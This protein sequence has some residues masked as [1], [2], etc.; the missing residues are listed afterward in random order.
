VLGALRR[1]LPEFLKTG[2]PLSP[3][4]RRAIWAITHCR[5][6]ALGGRA[7]A[8]DPCG[9][10]HFAYHSCNHKACPQ[11]GAQ[12]TQRWVDRELGKLVNAPYF[13]VTFTLP[14]ELRGC[15]FGPLAKEAYDLFFAAVSGALTEKL[16]T[17][18]GLRAHVNGFTAVLHTWTQQLEFHPHI[19]CLVPGA[20]LDDQGN[21]VHVK[22]PEYLVYLDHLQN[23]F[24]QHFYRLLKEHDWPVDPAVWRKDWGVHIQAAGSGSAAVKY[25]GRYIARTAI[26]DQRLVALDEHSVTFRWKNRDQD[27]QTEIRTLPGVEFVRRYLRHV[28][29]IGLRS[30]RYYGFCHPAAKAKRLRVQLH[31][32]KAV[33]FGSTP[34]AGPAP[35]SSPNC[36]HCGQPMR[37]ILSIP[38]WHRSRGPPVTQLTPVSTAA[39]A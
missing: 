19:H 22:R 5:T 39:A 38:P 28:L 29:P 17:D 8:C 12:S 1:F 3:Q 33:Q 7:F 27:N 36:P 20:G 2:P 16:A 24:R 13:L 34:S 6:A 35:C 10:I 32:G 14:A 21:Y 15:F 4:Q 23:A 25:L 11:C 30:I 31:S 18:K 37:Q 9:H 26:T